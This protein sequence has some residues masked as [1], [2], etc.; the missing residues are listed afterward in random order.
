[1]ELIAIHSTA[2]FLSYL[3]NVRLL[4]TFYYN[5]ESINKSLLWVVEVRQLNW[6]VEGVNKL[7]GFGLNLIS[8][9]NEVLVHLE[10]FLTIINVE[11]RKPFQNFSDVDVVN[12]VYFD[13]IL[14]KHENDIAEQ[15]GLSAEVSVRELFEYQH[16]KLIEVVTMLQNLR[17]AQRSH[18]IGN[19]L[20][21]FSQY[22]SFVSDVAVEFDV[23]SVHF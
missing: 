4:V 20:H 22:V 13:Q 3:R 18:V 2:Y 5:S 23:A 9:I 12:F 8:E 1:M 17:C 19:L 21:T 7:V 14:K 10:R 16:H 11:L 15:T 6:E